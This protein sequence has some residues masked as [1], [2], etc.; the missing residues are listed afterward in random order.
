LYR[1]SSV[2]VSV[3]VSTDRGLITPIVFGAER[4]GLVEIGITV[5]EL[6]AK[7]RAGKLQPH[8]FQVRLLGSG[9]GFDIGRMQL[10]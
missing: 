9:A 7:A 2:D 6:A 1:Y 4:K 8:E 3:A 10:Y 5:K